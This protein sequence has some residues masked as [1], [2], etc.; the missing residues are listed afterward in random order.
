MDM[1]KSSRERFGG[2]YAEAFNTV[3]ETNAWGGTETRSTGPNGCAGARD[4]LAPLLVNLV[5]ELGAKS[6]LDLGCGEGVWMPDLPGY[7]GV[8]VS[9][10]AIEAAKAFHPDRDHRLWSGGELPVCDLVIVRHVMQHMPVGDGAY[11]LSRIKKSGAKWLLATSFEKGNN[12]GS[13]TLSG[14]KVGGGYWP[15]L[16]AA[17]FSLG[18][19]YN[20][21]V[22]G[23]MS[24]ANVQNGCFLGLWKIDRN[25]RSLRQ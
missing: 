5:R 7:I 24:P 11:L 17:P 18:A 4:E 10:E 21:A 9:T 25:G 15:D 23:T 14:I 19:P 1:A 16:E 20:R 8:D 13:P 3:Y 12:A 2:K 6:V 22:D